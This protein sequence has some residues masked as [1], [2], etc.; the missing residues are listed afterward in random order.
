MISI[1]DANNGTEIDNFSID[2]LAFPPIPV[3]GNLL[4]LTAGGKLL[5][6]K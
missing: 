2:E 3:D 6:Y 5:A 1:V 4:F